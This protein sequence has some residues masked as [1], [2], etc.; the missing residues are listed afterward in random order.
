MRHNNRKQRPLLG[1]I[2]KDAIMLPICK[3]TS[4]KW[5]RMSNF[6]MWIN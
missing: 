6:N 5:Q 4:K 1:F 2:K 3:F